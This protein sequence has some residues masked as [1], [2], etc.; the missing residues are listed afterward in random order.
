MSRRSQ[1]GTCQ[2][3][4]KPTE[5][6]V[7]D[8]VNRWLAEGRAELE[9]NH[10]NLLNR[11]R[12]LAS[13]CAS[14][15]Y[16]QQKRERLI[17]WN[18]AKQEVSDIRKHTRER[19]KSEHEKAGE[20][21]E[22]ASRWQIHSQVQRHPEVKQA[23]Q[24][25]K[26][27]HELFWRAT[28]EDGELY[29]HL[30]QYR[31]ALLQD[32][33]PGV[34]LDETY[35]PRERAERCNAVLA[36]L[37]AEAPG[38]GVQDS[39]SGGTNLPPEVKARAETGVSGNAGHRLPDARHSDDFRSVHWFGHDFQFTATQAA[40]V[41]VLWRNWANR[42]PEVGEDTILTAPEVD[43]DAKRLIDV[44][45]EKKSPTGYH[46]AWGTM[47]VQGRKGAYR[48]IQPEKA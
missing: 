2:S 29:S 17:E 35:I 28:F 14:E 19:F 8:R 11:M 18:K 1:T 25:E 39:A 24:D 6:S 20:T 4:E 15:F 5:E 38:S 16:W 36:K 21:D 42:T 41:S 22:R 45:R 10:P 34:R 12:Y 3:A 31:P 7:S 32:F 37:L 33:G 13:Y 44:F 47:I 30:V 40:C 9:Q 27:A 43:A 48:L 23:E 46:A 26:T